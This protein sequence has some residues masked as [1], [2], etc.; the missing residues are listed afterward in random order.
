MTTTTNPGQ[1]RRAYDAACNA[2][3]DA[4]C[5]KHDLYKL[6]ENAGTFWLCDQPGTVL[7]AGDLSMDMA[8]ITEDINRDAPEGEFIRWY[9]YTLAKMEVGETPMNFRAWLDGA[10]R[11]SE[12]DI[13][14]IREQRDK[15]RRMMDEAKDF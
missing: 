11:M 6:G 1:L 15:L 10:P 12:A 8:T 7:F 9:D 4:F 13:Q 3:A 14:H 5:E 2:Y